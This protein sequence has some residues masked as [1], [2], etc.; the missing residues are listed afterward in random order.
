L[1][2]AAG[3]AGLLKASLA[4]QNAAITP[5]MHF[6]QLNEAIRPFYQHLQIPVTLQPWPELPQGTPR[7]ASVNS[8]GFGGTNAH[9]ILESYDALPEAVPLDNTPDRDITEAT[10]PLLFSASSE[11]SLVQIVRKYTHHIRR[12]NL[13]MQD[14]AW[15]LYHHRSLLPV[16]AAFAS[17]PREKV[18]KQMEDRIDRASQTPSEPFGTQPHTNKA[19]RDRILGIFTGQG[20]QWATM[21]SQLMK[22]SP[23]F[24]GKIRELDQAL[25]ELVDGPTWSLEI[26]LLRPPP[27]S[28]LDQAALSQP[29]CTAIQIALVHLMRQVGVEFDVVVGH[30]SGEIT[31]VSNFLND[32]NL[33]KPNRPSHVER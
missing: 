15:T 9:L 12:D 23:I 13:N 6:H 3:V 17:G 1:E 27:E 33:T 29:C 18:L 10:M 2:G 24:T 30:S 5:N 25:Q 4:L 21:G 16:R 22:N 31:A 11:I 20:A 14:L 32:L 19:V 7:R 28:R 26:E 8:F